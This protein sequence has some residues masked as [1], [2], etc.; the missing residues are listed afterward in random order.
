MPRTARNID[1]GTGIHGEFRHGEDEAALSTRSPDPAAL[2][3][4]LQCHPAI[5][6]KLAT[7][8]AVRALGL[9]AGAAGNPGDDAAILPRWEGSD[10]LSCQGVPPALTTRDPWLAGWCGVAVN[11]SSIAAMGG[12]TAALVNQ[13]WTPSVAL[14]EPLL[15]GMAAAARTFDVPLVGGHTDCSGHDLTLSVTALGYAETPVP[16]TGARPGHVLLAATDQRGCL[17]HLDRFCSGLDAP[18][19]RLRGDLEL[20]PRLAEEGLL[21]A[22]KDIGQAGLAGTVVSMA[23]C[24]DVGAVVDLERIVPPGGVSLQ[25]WL[26][27]WPSYGFLLAVAPG[28]TAAVQEEFTTRSIR[29]DPIG[30]VVEGAR[31]LFR[32]GDKCVPFWNHSERPYIG[33]SKKRPGVPAAFASA[34]AT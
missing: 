27:I 24:S 29:C 1:E 6:S 3:A 4:G 20:L 8:G 9:G 2:A 23:E 28:D 13:V 33:L 26:R 32:A 7:A 19:K 34:G 5:S 21:R 15:K 14:A 11:L 25:H 22:C 18:A 31:V 10:L 17:T 16:C 30:G 12:R